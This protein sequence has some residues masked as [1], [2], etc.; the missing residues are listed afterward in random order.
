MNTLVGYSVFPNISDTGS[1][2]SARI[3]AARYHHV[4]KNY[5]C[6]SADDDGWQASS[7]ATFTS[8]ITG[9]EDGFFLYMVTKFKGVVSC[10]K[11]NGVSSGAQCTVYRIL[12]L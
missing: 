6:Y 1:S 4:I 3:E 7:S 2:L 12:T 8:P 9:L 11:G 5:R 10:G